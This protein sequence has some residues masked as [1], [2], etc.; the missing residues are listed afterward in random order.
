MSEAQDTGSHP[1]RAAPDPAARCV[2]AGANRGRR[3]HRRGRRPARCRGGAAR[4]P[5][6]GA[7]SIVRAGPGKGRPVRS[8]HQ[9]GRDAA[10][11]DRR[12]RTCADGTRQADV[13][14][15]A[16]TRS[17]A[18]CSPKSHDVAAIVGAVT[19]YVARRM[20]EREHALVATPMPEPII[21]ERPSAAALD[22]RVRLHRRR[23]RLVRPRAA[24][25]SAQSL[26]YWTRG[27]SV[28]SGVPIGLAFLATILAIV[29]YGKW[30]RLGAPSSSYLT[31][32]RVCW[33]GS[34]N[35]VP[36]C[37]QGQRAGLARPAPVLHRLSDERQPLRLDALAGRRRS[38]ARVHPLHPR[39]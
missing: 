4:N 31:W 27:R 38:V 39:I 5:Q 14:L 3:P 28:A 34:K 10:A 1:V 25:H 29:L 21:V 36:A 2:A 23:G 12:G 16:G 18:S 15:R 17:A 22:L 7:R 32:P 13:P 35:I 37:A 8:R 11:V 9:P 33:S 26:G 24:R 20:I 30:I 6:R 19:D